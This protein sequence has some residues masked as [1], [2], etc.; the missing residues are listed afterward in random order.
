MKSR[1]IRVNGKIY[2]LIRKQ[3]DAYQECHWYR[4][5]ELD[6]PF[7]DLCDDIEENVENEIKEFCLT[8]SGAV[9]ITEGKTVFIRDGQW[10]IE[11]EQYANNCIATHRDPVV[12]FSDTFDGLFKED[13]KDASN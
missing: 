12:R 13:N 1:F 6:E 9:L 10:F 7:C 5:V 3:W 2:T 8:R 11:Y 4:V